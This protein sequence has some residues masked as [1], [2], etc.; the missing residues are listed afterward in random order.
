MS[1][2]TQPQREIST[3]LI[4]YGIVQVSGG[5]MKQRDAQVLSKLRLQII[6]PK[7]AKI[8][9][10]RVASHV[11][12]IFR[13]VPHHVRPPTSSYESIQGAVRQSLCLDIDTGG[14]PKKGA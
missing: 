4:V 14:P 12:P 7:Q 5:R 3:D 2:S 1:E 11:T 9:A 13:S 8:T 10:T 6:V